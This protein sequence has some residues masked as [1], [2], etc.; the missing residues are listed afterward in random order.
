MSEIV[1]IRSGD[2]VV[3]V[4][5]GLPTHFISEIGLNHNGSLEFAQRLVS[6]SV[7]AGSTFVKFQKRNPPALATSAFLDAG[8][9]K[10]P[11]FG[12]SQREVRE[13]LELSSSDY[14]QLMTHSA[15][16]GAVMF[17]S[18]FDIPSLEFLAD[19]GMGLIKVASHS[20]TNRP[21]LSAVNRLGLPVVLSLGGTTIEEKDLAVSALRDCPLILMHCVSEYPTP[22][23]RMQLD[24]IGFLRERYGMPVGFSSHESGV[25]FSLAAAV[26]GAVMIERHVT[27]SRSMPGPDHSISLLPS[28][29][30][31]LVGRTRRLERGRGVASSLHESEKVARTQYHVGVCSAGPI[32]A[33]T[34]IGLEML[35]FKQPLGDSAEFFTSWEVDQVLGLRADRDIPADTPIARSWLTSPESLSQ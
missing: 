19:T 23:Q 7:L 3:Q 26:L 22:D 1:T 16:L 24:T 5:E 35:A 14:R 31:D 15:S 11:F 9:P 4:G 17:A 6:E 28:E 32:P 27:L 2:Q 18:A 33:G 10:A 13:F 20:A 12:S 21:L 29:L 25:E 34:T 30:A 8:F